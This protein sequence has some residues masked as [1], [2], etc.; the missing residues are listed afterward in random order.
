MSVCIVVDDHVYG[1][2]IREH[3]FSK[4]IEFIAEKLCFSVYGKSCD[5][6]KGKPQQFVFRLKRI[7][8]SLPYELYLRMTDPIQKQKVVNTSEA[9][10]QG[11]ISGI[12]KHAQANGIPF[13]Y[14]QQTYT[15]VHKTP[16][17]HIEKEN[18]T[19]KTVSELTKI[20]PGVFKLC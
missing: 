20:S 17:K 11:I 14:V 1:N 2:D 10:Y 16:E 3:N 5:Q 9:L 15:N 18:E 7:R 12:K 6:I 13:T 19:K 8:I 4:V